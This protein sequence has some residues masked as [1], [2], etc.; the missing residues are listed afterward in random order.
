MQRQEL[1]SFLSSRI[2]WVKEIP[3]LL[4][5]T[6]RWLKLSWKTHTSKISKLSKNCLNPLP[7]LQL[8]LSCH[9]L[10]LLHSTK[11]LHWFPNSK[12]WKL[13][14]RSTYSL[15]KQIKMVLLLWANLFHPLW[16]NWQLIKRLN[17]S[18]NSLQ[19]QAISPKDYNNK[20]HFY[21]WVKS[22][23]KWTYANKVISSLKSRKSLA[24]RITLKKFA[25]LLLL[26]SV[27]LQLETCKQ[28][29]PKSLLKSTLEKKDNT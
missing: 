18:I 21:L 22:A 5:Y 15:V 25:L 6:Y 12:L 17:S 2:S 8:R 16:V 14:F 7:H 4:N 9:L 23:S 1:P 3:G 19:L 26:P 27:A 11:C 20:L 28:S 29:S 24:I 13:L 10:H